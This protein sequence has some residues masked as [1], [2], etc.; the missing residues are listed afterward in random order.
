MI[1][2]CTYG[3]ECP[4]KMCA[5][6]GFDHS[7]EHEYSVNLFVGC[8]SDYECEHDGCVGKN[9]FCKEVKK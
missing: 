3:D 9:A 8:D 6:S 1:V 2:K 7:V 4:H 5:Q